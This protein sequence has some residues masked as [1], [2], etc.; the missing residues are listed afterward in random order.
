MLF[1]LSERPSW[2]SA[3]WSWVHQRNGSQLGESDPGVQCQ[4]QLQQCF[5]WLLLCGQWGQL[6]VKQEGTVQTLQTGWLMR[7]ITPLLSEELQKI[8]APRVPLQKSHLSTAAGISILI[9][10]R[11]KQ[12]ERMPVMETVIYY[13]KLFAFE[14]QVCSYTDREDKHWKCCHV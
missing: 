3:Y 5:Q 12:K 4:H 14:S 7:T 10:L 6:S 2:H 8:R 9:L 13:V 11:V 1:L